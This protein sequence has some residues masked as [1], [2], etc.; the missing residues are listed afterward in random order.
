MG[1]NPAHNLLTSMRTVHIL[2]ESAP[3]DMDPQRPRTRHDD[4][5]AARGVVREAGAL[6]HAQHRGLVARVFQLREVEVP[7]VQ[8]RYAV[9]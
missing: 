9:D 3:T 8:T 5:L 1:E 6:L 2:A 7:A 4:G